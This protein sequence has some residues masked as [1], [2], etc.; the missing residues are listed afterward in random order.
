MS[1]PLIT[2]GLRAT[3]RG[4]ARGDK[5]DLDGAIQDYNEAI[6]L[7]PDDAEAF[8]NRGLARERK[9][10]EEGAIADYQRYLDLGGGERARDQ[11]EVEQMIRDLKASLTSDS[12][13]K[14]KKK[15]RK[16]AS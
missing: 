15:K 8:Y 7:K 2:G 1:K 6:R 11:S 4:N 14:K 3:N 13:K 9:N 12:K 16:K 5:G 10:D